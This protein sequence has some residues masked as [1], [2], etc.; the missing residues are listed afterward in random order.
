MELQAFKVQVCAK[1]DT[2]GLEMAFLEKDHRFCYFS[3][4]SRRT[5]WVFEQVLHNLTFKCMDALRTQ[6]QSL[7][8]F[9]W[10]TVFRHMKC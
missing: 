8:D 7:V 4:V 9:F 5:K 3:I 2:K 10:T 6:I 1:A